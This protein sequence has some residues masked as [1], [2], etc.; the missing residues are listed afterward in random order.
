MGLSFSVL[1]N[2]TTQVQ[3]NSLCY[4]CIDLKGI[5]FYEYSKSIYLETEKVLFE[6]NA[7]GTLIPQ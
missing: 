4:S 7:I 3:V 5:P 1:E 6:N 2:Y